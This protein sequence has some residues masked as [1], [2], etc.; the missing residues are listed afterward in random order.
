M[1]GCAPQPFRD[2]NATPG[3]QPKICVTICLYKGGDAVVVPVLIPLA[4]FVGPPKFAPHP[5]LDLLDSRLLISI[6]PP[7]ARFSLGT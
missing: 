3:V 4:G 1:S 6:R 2:L 7:L 5:M